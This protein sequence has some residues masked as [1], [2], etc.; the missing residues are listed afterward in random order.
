VEGAIG[1][2]RL[3]SAV[4]LLAVEDW[5]LGTLRK[6]REAQKF[7]FEE[8]DNFNRVCAGAGLEPGSFRAR[9]LKIGNKI[10]LQGRWQQP[11]AA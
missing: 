1:E 3:W 7:L 11:I 10:D 4:L 2:R 8:Q 9:L 6:R 5:R